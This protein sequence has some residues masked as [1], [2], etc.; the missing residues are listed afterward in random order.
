MILIGTT[1][2]IVPA[3]YI[4]R[5]AK[6]NNAKIIELNVERSLFTDTIT[7]IFIQEKASVSMNS[8]INKLDL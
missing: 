4:P 1:G 3:S 8:I 7:D 6:E 5:M 2:E